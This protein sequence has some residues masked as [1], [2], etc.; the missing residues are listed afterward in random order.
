MGTEEIA[1][2]QPD[3][4]LGGNLRLTSI[5]SRG[6]RNTPSRFTL[7]KRNISAGTDWGRLYLLP[8]FDYRNV[9]QVVVILFVLLS[10]GYFQ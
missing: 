1:W 10:S 9:S 5:I 8:Y 7:Q 4:M 3:K 6:S 2:G